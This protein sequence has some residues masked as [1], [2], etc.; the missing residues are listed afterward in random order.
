MAIYETSNSTEV[1]VTGI[2]THLVTCQSQPALGCVYKLVSINGNARIKLS[3]EVSKIVIPCR[4]N[5]YRLWGTRPFPLIDVMQDSDETPPKVGVQFFC[6]HPFEENKRA[7]IFPTRVENLIR[8]TWDGD[9]G[10]I[11]GTVDTLEA[12]RLRC[13]QQL[14]IMREDH[15]RPLNPTPF[16][17]S[18]S[19]S[20][21]DRIHEIWMQEAPVAELS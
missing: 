18:V 16:K 3:E 14:E 15:L 5:L 12:S 9:R 1:N 10:V 6:R 17:V 8:L 4:K 2:G 21:Y 7:T 11:P 13:L 20:M 19:S